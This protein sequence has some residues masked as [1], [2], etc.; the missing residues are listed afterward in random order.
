MQGSIY[1]ISLLIVDHAYVC[2]FSTNTIYSRMQS[3]W[4]HTKQVL[5]H[6]D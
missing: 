5:T 3:L 2:E 4:P 6:D 1:D